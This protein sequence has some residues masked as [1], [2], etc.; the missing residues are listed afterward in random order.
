MSECKTTQT[1]VRPQYSSQKPV[2]QSEADRPVTRL[3]PE[4]APLLVILGPTGSGKSDLALA[5][6]E[7]VGGE[8]LNCDSIQVYRGLNIGSAKLPVDQRRGIPHLLLDLL[9]SDQELTAGGFSRLARAAVSE[10]RQRGRVPIVTG[11]TGFYLRA[12]LDG[13]SPG[14]ARDQNLRSRLNEAA[15][16]HPLVLHRFLRRYDAGAAARIHPND[17]QKLIRA[18]EMICSSRQPLAVTHS[19]PRDA[20][21]DIAALKIGLDPER[22]TLYLRL[23]ERCAWM[24]RNGLLEETGELLRSGYSPESKALQSLG[25]KQAVAV[26]QGRLPVDSAIAECQTRTRQYAKRQMTWFR[27][28]RDV[29]WLS[30]FGFDETIQKQAIDLTRQFLDSSR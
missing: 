18:I 19:V 8:V 20:M 21:R 22:K 10:V 23:N 16:R 24:F 25:Y 28:E 9:D 1:G 11:G 5:L 13:L 29:H 30:G 4:L 14:P 12:L 7:I 26:L 6:A 27:R 2:S 17:R 3:S 15:H